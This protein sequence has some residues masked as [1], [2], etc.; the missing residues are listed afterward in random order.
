[1]PGANRTPRNSRFSNDLSTLRQTTWPP[2]TEHSGPLRLFDTALCAEIHRKT[3]PQKDRIAHKST[4]KPSDTA[5]SRTQAYLKN[6]YTASPS[7]TARDLPLSRT[8]DHVSSLQTT[9]AEDHPPTTESGLE[10]SECSI[11]D[12]Q[13]PRSYSR[14]LYAAMISLNS[15]AL[16]TTTRV[17]KAQP[18]NCC[19]AQ[20]NAL[21]RGPNAPVPLV[22][23]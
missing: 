12:H 1:M 2:T 10:T 23:Q 20:S 9:A 11:L 6:T 5:L 21:H 4:Q 19:V 18:M 22:D 16:P 13:T 14:A 17:W 8:T 7:R 15:R 3:S